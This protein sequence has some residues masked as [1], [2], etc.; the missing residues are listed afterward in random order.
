MS[1]DESHPTS[2]DERPKWMPRAGDVVADKYEVERVLGH[3]GMGVVVVARHRVLGHRVAIKYLLPAVA[4]DAAAVARFTR[5]AQ[6]AVALR[7]EH[8]ARVFDVGTLETGAPYMVMELLT[9]TDLETMLERD[10]PLD[11]R[12]AI[13]FV[14]QACEAIAEAHAL[15]IVHR[16]LKP[17]NLYVTQRPD[18]SP[19]VKVLDF[20]IAK[21]IETAAERPS[22]LTATGTTLGT[23]VY[24]SPEQIRDAKTADRRT[25]IWA[26]GVVLHH[27]LAGE[28]PFVGDTL[29]SLCAQILTE[30]AIPLAST[31]PDVPADL[32]AVVSRCLAKR[33]EDRFQD[34]G[35][36]AQAL[37][38]FASEGARIHVE[39][40]VRTLRGCGST[41]DAAYSS[42]APAWGLAQ[43][44]AETVPSSP[45]LSSV[46]SGPSP[47]QTAAAWQ[48]GLPGPD[49][50]PAGGRPALLRRMALPA[51]AG[52]ALLAVA[53]AWWSTPWST[54]SEGQGA[55]PPS[56]PPTL[57]SG[58]ST[59][60][61]QAPASAISP[62]PVAAAASSGPAEVDGGPGAARSEAPSE[63]TATA[64][65][66]AHAPLAPPSASARPSSTATQPK[67]SPADTNARPLLDRK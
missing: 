57:V 24:M 61:E 16:D 15:G 11:V 44:V 33:A 64:A 34:V 25:D 53:I 67:H 52:A 45:G 10:G 7:G 6:A 50:A 1:A 40:I 58:T 42:C 8:V 63:P 13:D 2:Q 32:A 21:T 59:A 20:G 46:S 35:E 31:R 9:G 65:G 27:L 17:S 37:A 18:G 39:R 60:F 47:K 14:L 43:G 62:A 55:P 23:P 56:S 36:L 49:A 29:P 51:L 66:N 4:H 30:P 41:P 19:L 48:T 38:P 26:L 5:E 22:M 54:R 3:G 12:C 28:P